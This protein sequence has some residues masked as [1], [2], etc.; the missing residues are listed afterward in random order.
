MIQN[1]LKFKDRDDMNVELFKQSYLC[2]DILLWINCEHYNS[3]HSCDPFSFFNTLREDFKLF[4]KVHANNPNFN[5]KFC[6]NLNLTLFENVDNEDLLF[7]FDMMM[8]PNSLNI[9]LQ[10]L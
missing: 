6:K 1:A 9:I 8:V 2:H 10:D 3:D 5:F 4:R 7:Y